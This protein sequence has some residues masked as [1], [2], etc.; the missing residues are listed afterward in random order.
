VSS[1]IHCDEIRDFDRFLELEADWNDL[2]VR[3]GARSFFLSHDW[4]R[5]CWLTLARDARPMVLVARE[6]TTVTGIVPL[7]T[8]RGRWR[9]FPATI[10]SLMENQDSPCAGVLLAPENAARTL[11][12]M[13]DHL[14]VKAGW[15]LLSFVKIERTS[16]M[17]GLLARCLA[18]QPH[19]RVGVGRSP[20]LA[21]DGDWKM[22]WTGRSQ[23]FKK[24]VRNVV[25]R[26]ERRGAVTIE[27]AGAQGT[28]A[29]CLQVF[30]D[31]AARSWKADLPISVMRNAEIARLFAL[32]TETLHARGQLVLW[33]LRIDGAPVATEYHVRDGDRIVALRSDFDDR[34][35]EDSPGAYLNYHIIRTYFEQGIRLYDM[36]PGDSEYKQRWATGTTEYDA[37]WFF[38]RT[39]YARALYTLERRA[40]PWLRRARGWFAG[41]QLSSAGKRVDV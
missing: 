38:N 5:C 11:A 26:I 39:P 9:V 18:G 6:G 24:T 7:M 34:Y 23:R 15:H 20:V 14:A 1:P 32:L 4:F 8:A 2:C 22:F 41:P 25:N 37:F 27:D 40:V 29:E 28:V 35:R 17:H 33:V 30:R 36:G 13:I 31:V 19:L 10:V 12:A 16:P 3:S 21:V